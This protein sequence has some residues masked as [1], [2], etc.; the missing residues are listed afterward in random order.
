MKSKAL[1]QQHLAALQQ[2]L[3]VHQSGSIEQAR[4]V[5]RRLYKL[6]PRNPDVLRLLGT[7]D[8][9]LGN[10]EEGAGY[11]RQSLKE[12]P[13]QPGTW[14]NLGNALKQLGQLEESLKAYD[15]ALAFKP[16]Y[17]E[18]SNNK[19]VVLRALQRFEESLA[20]YDK[21]VSIRQDYLDAHNNRGAVLKAMRRY[22]EALASYDR[23]LVLKPDYFE[24]HNNR[25]I[26]LNDLKRFQDSVESCIQALALKPDS[27][28]TYNC[29]GNAYRGQLLFKEAIACHER[30]I[31]L[32]PASAEAYNNR[33]VDF[34]KIG[35]YEEAMAN[36]KKAIELSADYAEPYNNLG[37]LLQQSNRLE[38]ALACLDTAIAL[39]PD[40]VE[41]Y[42]N[43]GVVLMNLNRLD[44]ALADYDAA[45][46]RDPDYAEA[47][48]N[49]A[50][51]LIL[52]GQYEQGWG[53]FEWRWLRNEAKTAGKFRGL[54][55]LGQE[56]ISGK[57]LLI[58]PEQGLGD[59]IQ[60]C[61]YAPQV[62]ALGAQVILEASSALVP[63]LSTLPGNFT[64][65][66]SGDPLPQHDALCPL[67]SLP[68]AFK[69]TIDTIP[70]NIPYFFADPVKTIE[71]QD[72]IGA[73]DQPRIGL[74]WSGNPTHKNDRNRSLSLSQMAPLFDLPFEFHCLQ[75]DIREEDR[76]TL[77]R[78]PQLDIHADEL[79]DF[80][81]T[82]ALI[83][84]MDLVISVDTSVAH[85]A[86]AMGKPLW[87]LLPY[88]P[89]YRWMLERSD[90][91]WYPSARLFRQP[92]MGDW[93]YVLMEVRQALA[94]LD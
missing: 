77:Q 56:S 35:L 74:V 30:A 38:E 58:Y 20:C 2:A 42:N 62:E 93:N 64:I 33:A 5:Y 67:M 91:P 3:A 31:R 86:G 70:A 53:L 17:A 83:E 49:K 60:F 7:A 6:Y 94:A 4:E 28:E 89:D 15:K 72:R 46:E 54:P 47:H 22:E 16:D 27:A 85:L 37:M 84:A 45:I 76:E 69:T 24:A 25:A 43:R 18:A 63:V 12:Q 40:Y 79:Q 61:R 14:N 82:A 11:L 9:Q 81:D 57:T 13:Q 32:D 48:W 21:A 65:V 78:Y 44:Q 59:Y 29:L 68:L 19:G 90:S 23:A 71:W 66:A 75:K 34:Q 39:M 8:Y 55:W 88:V 10:L 80:S 73:G 52:Q 51:L 1:T 36:C 41:A 87:L 92:A 26:V 50:L